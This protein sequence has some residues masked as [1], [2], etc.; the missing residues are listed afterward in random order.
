VSFQELS[1]KYRAVQPVLRLSGLQD[2]QNCQPEFAAG[3][4]NGASVTLASVE[5]INSR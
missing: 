4:I 3:R 1:G 2:G 5:V